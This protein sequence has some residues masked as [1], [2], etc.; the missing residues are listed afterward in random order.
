LRVT[1]SKLARGSPRSDCGSSISGIFHNVEIGVLIGVLFAFPV[2][3]IPVSRSFCAS[4]SE[5]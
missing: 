5:R 1:Q 3:D 2:P 4:L